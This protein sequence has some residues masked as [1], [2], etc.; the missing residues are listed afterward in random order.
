MTTIDEVRSFWDANPLFTGES[1]HAPGSRE[2][3]DEHRRVY[4][5]DCFAGDLDPRLF[6]PDL[7]SK[8]VL[9]LGCG[10]GFWLIELGQRG[11][12]DLTGADLSPKSLEIASRRCAVYGVEAN[13]QEENAERLSFPDATFDHV[14]C[15]GVVHHTTDPAKAVREIYRVLKRISP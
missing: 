13:L 14:N 5:K 2:F 4:Y 6:P 8:K 1:R 9:D 11:C 3:F 15:Q 7:A 12:R 10:V